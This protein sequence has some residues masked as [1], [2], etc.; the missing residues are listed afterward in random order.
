MSPTVLEP[1]QDSCQPEALSH[2]VVPYFV[3]GPEDQP[4]KAS[5]LMKGSIYLEF[6]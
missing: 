3:R 4:I 2:R 6:I 5:P 1:I